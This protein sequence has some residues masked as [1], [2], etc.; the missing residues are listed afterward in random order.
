M[1]ISKLI[2]MGFDGATTFSGKHRG[3]GGGG[4]NSFEE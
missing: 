2:G 3:G 4:T 1:Q